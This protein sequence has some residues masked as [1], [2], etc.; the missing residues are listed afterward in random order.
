MNCVRIYL[1]FFLVFL[2]SCKSS[3]FSKS[4]SWQKKY[5]EV[6]NS[7]LLQYQFGRFFEEDIKDESIKNFMT[8][9]NIE[10]ICYN[11]SGESSKYYK[12]S[13]ITFEFHYNPFFGK[14]RILLYKLDSNKKMDDLVSLIPGD[15][16][17]KKINNDFVY[18]INKSPGFGE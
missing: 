2:L 18:I 13:T 6:T 17:I 8:K 1:L 15:R 3:R 14:K 9:E 10:I 5:R 4:L 11:K 7:I 12:D 16:K